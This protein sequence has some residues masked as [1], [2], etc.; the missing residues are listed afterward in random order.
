MRQWFY[1]LDHGR[2]RFDN[3]A[4]NTSVVSNQYVSEKMDFRKLSL[5]KCAMYY[6]QVK[7]EG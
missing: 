2:T 7:N 6:S 3:D 5:S 4:V 1:A